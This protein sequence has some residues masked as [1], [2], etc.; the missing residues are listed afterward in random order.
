[1]FFR[2]ET[3]LSGSEQA[4]SW[5]SSLCAFLN[6]QVYA[7]KHRVWPLAAGLS[8][9]DAAGEQL[10]MEE[11]AEPLGWRDELWR[12][13]FRG[14]G[15]MSKRLPRVS[16]APA[17]VVNARSPCPR[18]C[19]WKHKGLRR[20]SCKTESCYRSCKKLH[21]PILRAECPHREAIEALIL[22]EHRRREIEA[23]IVEE[24]IAEGKRC[25][26]SMNLCPLRQQR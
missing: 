2:S 11:L 1:V 19:T 17:R 20:D 23:R 16:K 9:G 10:A 7:E 8:H 22:L 21:K 25:C 5:W 4:A 3:R 24:L 13:M 26:E 14:K 6:N 15:W 18:G 12:G